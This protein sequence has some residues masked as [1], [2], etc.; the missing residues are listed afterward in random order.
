MVNVGGRN[1][2]G[3][4]TAQR[5]SLEVRKKELDLL[6]DQGTAT[7]KQLRELRR[8]TATLN[9]IK[10]STEM[11]NG[12]LKISSK[13]KTSKITKPLKGKTQKWKSQ[14]SKFKN[15]IFEPDIFFNEN[16]YYQSCCY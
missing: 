16:E 13:M 2:T 11:K 3:E 10:K 5:E 12:K 15:S 4:L 1:R 7:Y 9:K 8:V 14:S 6:K